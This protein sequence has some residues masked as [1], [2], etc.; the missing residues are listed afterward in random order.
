MSLTFVGLLQCV[1]GLWILLRGS[2]NSAFAFLLVSSLFG[3][4]AA[5]HL[6]ALGNSSIPPVQFALLFVYFR[7]LMPR[8]GYT[9][10]IPGALRANLALVLFTVWGIAG[11][12]AAPR[13]FAGAVNVAPMRFEAARSL[14]DTVPLEPTAQNITSAV[15]LLGALLSAIAVQ[16]A[17]RFRGGANA[18]V[19]TGVAL[20]WIHALTGV[21][22]VVARGTP[23][24]VVFDLFRN[25]SYAQLDQSYQGFV[26]INGVHPEAS[27]Y[28]S[29]GLAW[30]FFNCECW[31]RSILPRATGR[32]ALALAV[33][34]FFST[35]STA[36]IGLST[37]AAFFVLRAVLVSPAADRQ[38]LGQ[39]AIAA[40]AALSLACLAM[41]LVPHLPA[42]VWDMILHMTVEKEDSD[43]G[44]QRL[45]WA[46]Q[47][48]NAFLASGGLGI[49]A[50]SFRSSSL[51]TAIIGSMGVI[52]I[53]TF[54][55][56]VWTVLQPLRHSTWARSE[57]AA[58]SIGGAAACTTLMIL[59]PS[60]IA[61]PSP[62]PGTNFAIFA[63][64]ALGLR[65]SWRGSR[66]PTSDSHAHGSAKIGPRSRA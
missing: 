19:K 54:A 55:V 59:V 62:D 36:Y 65:P 10:A 53:L 15:Y 28:A 18:L 16:I 48:W 23:A 45:F 8:G 26:R 25:A 17:C 63:G 52:G 51:I 64:A 11:A 13:I 20:A 14:L 66:R 24:E 41:A 4:S 12:V 3:G 39:A 43:S 34:L 32:A 22:G 29:F 49:G 2:L 46:M 27:A 50:G 44:R 31:Y 61:A 37:Y 38:R 33:V 21:I 30:F 6:T 40:I 5:A 42:A 35:S 7:L 1:F 60:S 47:G 56:Y 57:D 9:G 58:L